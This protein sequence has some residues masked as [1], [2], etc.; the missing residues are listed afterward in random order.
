MKVLEPLSRY[1]VPP[2]GQGMDIAGGPLV[3]YGFGC[4]EEGFSYFVEVIPY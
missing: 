2:F 1:P 4:L 3:A